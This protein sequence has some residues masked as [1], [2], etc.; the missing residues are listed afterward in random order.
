[1]EVFANSVFP[2]SMVVPKVWLLNTRNFT[3]IARLRRYSRPL[4]LNINF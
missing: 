4:V 2:T 3:G 1:M